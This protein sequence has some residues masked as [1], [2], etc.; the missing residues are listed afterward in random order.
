DSVPLHLVLTAKLGGGSPPDRFDAGR[1]PRP[2]GIPL[3]PPPP[4]AAVSR[5][6]QPATPIPYR[7]TLPNR[8]RLLVALEVRAPL[9]LLLLERREGRLLL[10]RGQQRLDLLLG[11]LADRLHLLPDGSEVPV[12]GLEE[13]THV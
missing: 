12:G 6:G 1:S 9:R 13:R 7:P 8:F 5:R 4:A 10:G 11:R 2:V 3:S